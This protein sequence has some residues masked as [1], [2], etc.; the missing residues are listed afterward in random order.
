MRLES[1]PVV[2]P[3]RSNDQLEIPMLGKPLLKKPVGLL[4][5]APVL[6]RRKGESAQLEHE[7][8]E[9]G[10]G[11]GE[12][13]E[14]GEREAEHPSVNHTEGQPTE[15]GE[16]FEFERTEL[17][18]YFQEKKKNS[19]SFVPEYW[20][21]GGVGRT[22]F[23]WY[24][25]KVF[26]GIRARVQHQLRVVPKILQLE[27]DG[28]K[29]H[30]AS[31]LFDEPFRPLSRIV[32]TDQTEV[33]AQGREPFIED[34]RGST[35]L[36]LFASQ[37]REAQVLEVWELQGELEDEPVVTERAMEGEGGQGGVE[38]SETRVEVGLPRDG[39][40]VVDGEGVDSV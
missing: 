20:G 13:R 5:P 36:D 33:P 28:S 16:L 19:V 8:G 12:N 15:D 29:V 9:D 10:G 40:E 22:G 1:F 35:R 21:R 18:E 31:D 23:S 37:P 27:L 14:E 6:P 7:L 17:V 3:A 39:V 26:D 11:N 24:D 2:K 4:P 32:E 30:P 38:V 34:G 25:R